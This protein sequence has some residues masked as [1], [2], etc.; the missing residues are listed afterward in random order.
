V[1][2]W[3][4]VPFLRR[5]KRAIAV[6]TALTVAVTMAVTFIMPPSYESTATLA[7]QPLTESEPLSFASASQMSARNIGELVKSPN[8]EAKA[9]EALGKAEIEGDQ[10]FRVSENTGLVMISIAGSDPAEAAREANALADA[11]LELN[12]ET[13]RTATDKAQTTIDQQL[14][15]LRVQ[16]TAAENDLTAARSTPDGAATVTT[17]QDKLDALNTSYENV[18]QDLQVLSSSEAVLSTQV[19]LADPAVAEPEPVSPLPLLNLAL[20]MVGGLLLGIAYARATE[21][22]VKVK[23]TETE[24]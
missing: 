1:E 14:T 8:V 5:H 12:D 23:D 16:I 20:A 15:R 2:V 21:A 22:L 6:I 7:V 17:L 4:W 3:E 19:M 9:A 10:S 11:F 24:D 13:L 18:L